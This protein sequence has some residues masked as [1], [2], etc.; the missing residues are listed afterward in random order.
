[1]GDTEHTSG[2]TWALGGRLD[3]A[4][5][6]RG[7]VIRPPEEDSLCEGIGTQVTVDSEAVIAAARTLISEGL[8]ECLGNP[9]INSAP[10]NEKIQRLVASPD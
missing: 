10:M 1:M 2:Q 7:V 3:Q 8:S 9:T 5:G 4:H 6:E